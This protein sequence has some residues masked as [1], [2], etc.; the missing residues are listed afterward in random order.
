MIF[1]I[2]GTHGSGKSTV[3]VRTRDL[4]EEVETKSLADRK[5]PVGYFC[6]SSIMKPLFIVGSYQVGCDGCDN[7]KGAEMVF[8]MIQAAADAGQSV[9]FE[10][11]IIQCSTQR[12]CD[13]AKKH[14]LSLIALNT[15]LQECIDAVTARRVEKGQDAEFSTAN[16]Q[17]KYRRMTRASDNM[18]RQGLT[19]HWLSRENAFQFVKKE[20]TLCTNSG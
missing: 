15:S 11:I 7:L 16:L 12:I 2:R 5:R 10:G 6:R 17:E 8:E 9:I 19:T 20:L 1:N 3:V 4:Y 13:L 18:R 14:P